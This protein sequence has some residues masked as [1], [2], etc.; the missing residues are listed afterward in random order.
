[1]TPANQLTREQSRALLAAKGFNV[2]KVHAQ[3]QANIA[4]AIAAQSPAKR[5]RQS[6]KPLMNRLESE[7]YGYLESRLNAT[8]FKIHAQAKRYRLGNGIWFKPDFTAIL[9]GVEH[10]WET[11]GPK[12]F[13]GGFENLKVAA[14]LYPEIVWTL[15]W[16]DKSTGQWATQKILP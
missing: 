3:A 9:G 16:K 12:A 7:F 13:R 11:K 2:D 6:G 10:A 4:A 14:S 8:C 1:M 5:I 15:A